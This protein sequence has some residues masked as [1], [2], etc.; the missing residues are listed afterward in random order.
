VWP[1][2]LIDEIRNNNYP[3][4]DA[5]IWVYACF[6]EVAD[7]LFEI[8]T[9]IVFSDVVEKEILRWG[10]DKNFNKVA[11]EYK[12][13][14]AEG[15]IL[16][17]LHNVHIPTEDRLILESMLTQ[18]GFQNYFENSPPEKDKGEYVSAIYAD[19]LG[20][21][22]FKTNDKLFAEEG[23]GRKDFPYLIINNWYDTLRTLAPNDS[24]FI[25]INKKM[26]QEQERCEY[27]KEK[28]TKS[29]GEKTNMKKKEENLNWLDSLQKKWN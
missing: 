17:I 22:L 14:K 25:S 3:I 29:Q 8:H 24:A 23:R 4:C 16:V 6:G 13:Y 27:Y 7:R 9:K 5:D 28:H 1:D 11:L 12:K 21:K 20:I 19:Y 26:Q 2:P 15:K 10:S 18:F